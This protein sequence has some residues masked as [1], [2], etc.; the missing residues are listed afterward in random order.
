LN[1]AGAG[2]LAKNPG[3]EKSEVGQ[4]EVLINKPNLEFGQRGQQNA[5]DASPQGSDTHPKF[6]DPDGTPTVTKPE[7]WPRFYFLGDQLRF[8]E[9]TTP[10]GVH[11]RAGEQRWRAFYQAGRTTLA[12]VQAVITMIEPLYQAKRQQR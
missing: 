7:L 12:M 10:D 3:A 1:R 11:V 8:P 4:L 5:S 2:Q 6:P 9:V